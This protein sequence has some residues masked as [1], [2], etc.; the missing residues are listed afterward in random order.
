MNYDN[1]LMSFSQTAQ[2][3]AAGTILMLDP[4]PD[5]HLDV[6]TTSQLEKAQMMWSEEVFLVSSTQER[7]RRYSFDVPLPAKVVDVK[8]A[9]RK[10]DGKSTVVMAQP[11]RMLAGRALVIAWYGAI[12]EALATNSE[13]RVFRLFEAA[14][15][16]PIRLRL[17]PGGDS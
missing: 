10:D 12:S 1:L 16:V 2:Y 3:E 11:L 9:Q 5:S 4:I 6:I 15:S 14:L 7:N 8:V 13:E 17:C